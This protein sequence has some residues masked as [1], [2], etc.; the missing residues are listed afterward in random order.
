MKDKIYIENKLKHLKRCGI[1]A[2]IDP[3]TGG[4]RPE[5]IKHEQEEREKRMLVRQQR[6]IRRNDVLQEDN[7]NAI[8]NPLR[9]MSPR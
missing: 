8:T 2:D 1:T 3:Q 5:W 9:L 4:V 7:E 6:G